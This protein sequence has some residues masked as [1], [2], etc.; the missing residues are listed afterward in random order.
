MLWPLLKILTHSGHGSRKE[1]ERLIR[2]RKVEVLGEVCFDPKKKFEIENLTYKIDDSEFTFKEFVYLALNKPKGYECSHSP[3][4]HKSVF[5]L[6]PENFLNRGVKA[7]GRLDVDTTGL[8]LFTDDGKFNSNIMSPK[9]K[10]PKT[11]HVTLKHEIDD[12]LV[13]KLLDGVYL[14]D[15][16]DVLVQAI[17]AEKLEACLLKL[18]IAEGK[19]HQVKRMVAACSN[20][21]EGLHREEIG[22]LNLKSL[23]LSEGGIAE[24]SK[25]KVLG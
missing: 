15:E 6:V 1:C 3:S 7:C 5:E 16:P 11:Y 9:K 19:Y 8:L 18:K 13:Q 17:E 10:L 22:L 14:N 12:Q 23:G 24:V 20:R 21:V 25:E 2:R 4:H